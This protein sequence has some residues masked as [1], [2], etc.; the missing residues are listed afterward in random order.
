MSTTT[1]TGTTLQG[2]PLLA[3]AD[4]D[5]L[6]ELAADARPVRV[7]AGDWVLREGD[8]ADDLFVVVRGRLRVVATTGGEERTLR[9]LGPGAAIG[10]LA[11][12]TGAARSASVQAVRDSTLLRLPRGPFVDLLGRDAWFAAAMANNPGA[13]R[14]FS[15]VVF[16]NTGTPVRK[17]FVSNGIP[18]EMT[19]QNDRFQ[20]VL[21][22]EAIQRV[23]P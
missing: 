2:V 16:D 4:A 6:D 1:V 17:F 22:A 19:H 9:V 7:L 5:A 12:L 18:T 10:E 21:A 23:A 3:G 11:L 20:I 15:L 14:S 13:R 8:A